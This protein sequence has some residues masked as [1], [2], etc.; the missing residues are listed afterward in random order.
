MNFHS[1][2]FFGFLL[3]VLGLHQLLPRSQRRWLLLAASYTFYGAWDWRF[4]GLIL[5]STA[6]DWWL[7]LRIADEPVPARR[8][9]WIV[10]SVVANLGILGVF[11]Y[12]DFFLAGFCALTGAD[13]NDWLLHLVLPPGI[14]FFTF[15]SM[16][17]TID[18]YRG[19]VP[20]RRSFADFALFVA[21]FPQLVA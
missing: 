16:S 7:A 9:R 19:H 14:S 5:L 3:L 21:F 20:A 2:V 18:V 17:Y 4:L 6:L 8:R 10:L 15:Q 13:P 12:T 11:K 1:F